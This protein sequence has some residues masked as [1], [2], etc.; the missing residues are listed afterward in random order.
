MDSPSTRST[1]PGTLKGATSPRGV[2]TVISRSEAPAN[3]DGV[4][5]ADCAR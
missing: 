3:G 4:S 1:E 2:E 5:V